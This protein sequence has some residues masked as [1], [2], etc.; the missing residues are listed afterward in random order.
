MIAVFVCA[1]LVDD[2]V[3]VEQ[4]STTP[5]EQ[6]CNTKNNNNANNT[7]EIIHI[8]I[9]ARICML[10]CSADDNILASVFR[11]HIR[12]E[13]FQQLK[14]Y[15]TEALQRIA[16][17]N[18]TVGRILPITD[19]TTFSNIYIKHY[20]PISKFLADSGDLQCSNLPIP[21]H[22]QFITAHNKLQEAVKKITTSLNIVLTDKPKPP[23]K[24]I[25]TV[26]KAP[27]L[28]TR[29]PS[30]PHSPRR[31][32]AEVAHVAEPPK[33]AH[34]RRRSSIT[35]AIG[36]LLDALPKRPIPAAN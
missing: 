21:S 12:Q 35:S 34:T 36:A 15:T 14:H 17:T 19:H 32:S 22:T 24:P 29:P 18:D 4:W 13:I 16:T 2:S 3:P 1:Q 11:G 20:T 26:L 10:I 6:W 30:K 23:T 9:V 5:L 8:L 31:M 28:P 33:R 27:P 7:E 25:S